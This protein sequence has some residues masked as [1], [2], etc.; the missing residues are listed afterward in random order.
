MKSAVSIVIPTWNG[1]ELLKRFF[2]SVVLAS[3]NYLEETDSQ[4]EIIVVDDGG[5]DDSYEWLT[6]K[7]NEINSEKQNIE[8]RILRNEENL[9]FGATCA[10]GIETAKFPLLF[11]LNNDVEISANAILPLVENFE[12][13]KLF[14][15]HCQA[16]DFDE[17]FVCGLGKVGRFSR[18]FIRVH[19]SYLEK[20][21]KN[22]KYDKFYS[23]FASGGAAMFDREKFLEIGGFEKLLYPAYW[24]DI[25]ISYRAWKRGF[26]IVYEPRAIVFHRVSSTMRKVN[27]KKLKVI[28]QRNRIIFNWINMHDRKMFLLHFYWLFIL[29]IS[30]P[31]T[32]K[33]SFLQGFWEALKNFS[34]IRKRRAE[35]KRA[36]KLSDRE[37]F[38]IFAELVKR[39]DLKVYKN[40]KELEADNKKLVTN[41]NP[42]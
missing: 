24:E 26:T 33:F 28:N 12:D 22:Q 27:S 30:A 36:A 16:F 39:D 20:F 8:L 21:D 42:I 19:L 15:A 18:G 6:V 1:I 23:I 2:P 5:T 34:E 37:V 38:S 14:A 25:D 11:L 29:L 13:K 9:G 17:K 7:A 41:K 4:V 31:L 32:M 10:K 3:E 40:L 35:E